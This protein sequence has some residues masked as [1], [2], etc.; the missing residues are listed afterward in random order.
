MMK[1]RNYITPRNR[2]IAIHLEK[3][4]LDSL[5][6]NFDTPHNDNNVFDPISGTDVTASDWQ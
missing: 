3:F 5:E 1:K 2:Y 6:K 4:F